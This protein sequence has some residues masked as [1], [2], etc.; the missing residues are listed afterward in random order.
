MVGGDRSGQGAASVRDVRV[1]RRLWRGV[2]LWLGIPLAVLLGVVVLYGAVAFGLLLFPVG[3]I[4]GAGKGDVTAYVVSNGVHTDFVFPVQSGAMDWRAVFPV[5][6]VL[7]R[8][9]ATDYI[10]I[11][12]GDREFYLNTPEWKD[13]TASRALHAMVGGDA[14]LIHVEYLSRAEVMR[15]SERYRLDLSARQYGLLVDYVLKALPLQQGVGR[16]VAG[17]HYDVDDAFF[18]AYGSYSALA[19]CNTW[20]GAGL[21]QA[22]VRVSRWT[23]LD[24]TVFWYLPADR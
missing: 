22:G 17:A 23:P 13:L 3:S 19:T 14:G 2:K 9:V 11:G 15:F 12:W 20:V 8:Q 1:A 4:A 16:A 6:A 18:E 24:R 7:G 5:G 21:A 10:S